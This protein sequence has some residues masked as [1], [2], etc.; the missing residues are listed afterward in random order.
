MY[1]HTNYDINDFYIMLYA[2]TI[3]INK[4]PRYLVTPLTNMI[5]QILS[6]MGNHFYM[7]R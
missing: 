7:H 4:L 3:L 6:C 1:A 2:N 5:V